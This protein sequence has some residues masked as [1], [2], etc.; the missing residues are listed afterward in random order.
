MPSVQI[1]PSSHHKQRNFQGVMSRVW[2][3]DFC[4]KY[5]EVQREI[6]RRK[7]VKF[8]ALSVERERSLADSDTSF[9]LTRRAAV[10]NDASEASLMIFCNDQTNRR[11]SD[12][13][14]MWHQRCGRSLRPITVREASR[15]EP[16]SRF[17]NHGHHGGTSTAARLPR[18]RQR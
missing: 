12:H 8:A 17:R 10:V 14:R 13:C 1:A 16:S 6:E 2:G 15:I 5:A 11:E 18:T 7:I 9:A 4:W 3:E